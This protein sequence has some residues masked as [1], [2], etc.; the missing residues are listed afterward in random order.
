MDLAVASSTDRRFVLS[1]SSEL[2]SLIQPSE[3]KIVEVLIPVK[4]NADSGH[5]EHP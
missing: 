5:R 2:L 4:M 3:H 1:L